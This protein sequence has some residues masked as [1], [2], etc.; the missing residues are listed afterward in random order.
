M[1]VV[2][3][4]LAAKGTQGLVEVDQE[5]DV[6]HDEHHKALGHCRQ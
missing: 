2:L 4:K 1:G 6:E 5:G 3:F